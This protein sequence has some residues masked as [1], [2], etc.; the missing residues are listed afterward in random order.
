M[1]KD[2]FAASMAVAPATS[3]AAVALGSNQPNALGE[4]EAILAWAIE[5][6]DQLPQTRVRVASRW[7]RTV[8]VG[9][10]QPDYCNG[11]VL[12]DTALPPHGLL[13]RMLALE[14]QMGRE[15]GEPQVR[16]GPRP[17]DL[18]LLFY[19]DWIIET[20]TL[21][22]PHPRMTERGFV[23]LPLADVAPD[24]VHP[25]LGETIAQ[26][27]QRVDRS[28]VALGG[29]RQG[30]AAPLISVNPRERC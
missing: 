16:W 8:A 11:A 24:W 29:E 6:L 19:G 20:P 25:E 13:E 28:G 7:Y 17:L 27:A 3:V 10:P 23:L 12:L 14:I 22:V 15:R 9:P 2:L 1:L 18:D 4:P 21:Q 26:L 5:A 30:S